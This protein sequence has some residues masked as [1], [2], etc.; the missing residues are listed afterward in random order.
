MPAAA[1]FLFHK[2]TGGV[3]AEAITFPS[4]TTSLALF[5]PERVEAMGKTAGQ[6]VRDRYRVYV[7]NGK[8]PGL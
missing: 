5:L 4:H 6:K 8:T 3:F 1:C 2:G 7:A